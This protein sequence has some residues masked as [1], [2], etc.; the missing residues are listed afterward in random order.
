MAGDAGAVPWCETCNR[1]YNSNNVAP[2]GTCVR[3]GRFIATPADEEQAEK[4]PGTPW[5]FWLFV[6]A[7]ALYLGW[8]FVQVLG[9]LF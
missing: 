4:A 2:D 3:C 6:V 7:L 1:F 5:H 9:W 8:R